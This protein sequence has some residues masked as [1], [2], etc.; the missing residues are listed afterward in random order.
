MET[1]ARAAE[2]CSSA[3]YAGYVMSA[4]YQTLLV[5][6]LSQKEGPRSL[7]LE[8]TPWK[9]SESP[10]KADKSVTRQDSVPY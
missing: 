6:A 9:P 2:L 4:D 7:F 5:P 8:E 3:S 10:W 1:S